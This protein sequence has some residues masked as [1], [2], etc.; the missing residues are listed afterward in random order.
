[1]PRGPLSHYPCLVV[2]ACGS[3]SADFT[4]FSIRVDRNSNKSC[5]AVSIT[6]IYVVM[7]FYVN[8]ETWTVEVGLHG[9]TV[10]AWLRGQVGATPLSGSV[11]AFLVLGLIG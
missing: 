11:R 1:M 10:E 4:A 9:G 8:F 5:C 6:V 2:A 3:T 7:Q